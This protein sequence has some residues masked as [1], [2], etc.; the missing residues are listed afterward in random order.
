MVVIAEANYYLQ[1]GLQ[2]IPRSKLYYYEQLMMEGSNQIQPP[3][4]AQTQFLGLQGQKNPKISPEIEISHV[5]R[6]TFI[7]RKLSQL[8]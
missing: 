3:Q 8:A 7:T 2:Q 5:K 4:S 6:K 1:T